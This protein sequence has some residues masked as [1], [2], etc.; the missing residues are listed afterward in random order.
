MS[1]I[2]GPA[3]SLPDESPFLGLQT[4]T[5]SLCPHI[6]GREEEG[7]EERK[8]TLVLLYLCWH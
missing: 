3:D 8:Y 4:D 6:D 1:N 2:K 5:V 7:K